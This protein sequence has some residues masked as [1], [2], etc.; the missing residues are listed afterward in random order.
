MTNPW[1]EI[2][3]PND[4]LTVRRVDSASNVD[5]FWGVDSSGDY[6]F[7]VEGMIPDNSVA[8]P[9][10][11]DFRCAI[12][13]SGASDGTVRLVLKLENPADWEFFLA[14]CSDLFR[15]LSAAEESR[16]LSVVSA[17]LA[18]WRSFL[19]SG[20]GILLSGER[21]R[22]LFG[23]LRFL[24]DRLAPLRGWRGAVAAWGGPFG[25]TRDFAVAGA[26]IEAKA[27]LAGAGRE[28]RISSEE[29]LAPP[30]GAVLFLFVATLAPCADDSDGGGESLAALV[31]RVRAA[32]AGDAGTAEALE[33]RLLA[34]GY[35]DATA[36]EHIAFSVEAEEAFRVEGDFPRLPPEALPHGV[37]HVSYGLDLHA[38]EAFRAP[39]NWLEGIL[40]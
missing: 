3:A 10:F 18:K 21:I 6:F 13:P 15:A 39:E 29:Q 9:E 38:C 16:A 23:E 37:R 7:L 12:A 14:L 24:A 4:N 28:V 20:R 34:A 2:P 33:D 35:A 17:R 8:M 25:T 11:E 32:V 36:Y 1:L 26:E 5:A 31:R 19:R 27:K 40:K 22:G 30:P